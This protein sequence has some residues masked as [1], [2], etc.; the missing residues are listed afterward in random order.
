VTTV[1]QRQQQQY[2]KQVA[3]GLAPLDTAI[4]LMQRGQGG[5]ADAWLRSLWLV[6][7][8]VVRDVLRRLRE[9]ENSVGTRC[10]RDNDDAFLN[11]VWRRQRRQQFKDGNWTTAIGWQWWDS[12]DVMTMD[13]Q[14]HAERLQVLRH[15]SKA[16]IN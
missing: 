10:H 3:N 4:S 5:T 11:V 12:N 9:K 15:P 8:T 6:A 7:A 16:S 2:D 14:P 13:G 1:A